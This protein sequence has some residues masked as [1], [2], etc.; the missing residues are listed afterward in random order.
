MI[1]QQK[2][3]LKK[4]FIEACLVYHAVLVSGVQHSD[5]DIDIKIH[6][7]IFQILLHSRLLQDIEYS[8]LICIGY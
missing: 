8:S 5:S 1:L 2:N 4:I 6:I 3:K 7:Y